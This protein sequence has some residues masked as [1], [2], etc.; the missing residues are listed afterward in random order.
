MFKIIAF[1]FAV[2]ACVC[3]APKPDVIAY[4]APVVAAPFVA[5]SAVVSREFHG[6]TANY[7]ATYP[8]VEAYSAPYIA[9][10]PYTA[11]A[12]TVLL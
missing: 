1:V 3:A 5:S 4:S 12:S 9:A 6:N 10:A 11:Y 7:V 2:I 8:Y